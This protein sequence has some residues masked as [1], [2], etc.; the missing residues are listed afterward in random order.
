MSYEIMRRKF[1]LE[2]VE[3]VMGQP[4]ALRTPLHVEYGSGP[5]FAPSGPIGNEYITDEKAFNA[6]GSRS[7]SK[8][9]FH[10]PVLDL[11]GGAG[12]QLVGSGSKA[13]I[14]ADP[15]TS[16]QETMDMYTPHSILRDILG[17]NKIEVEIFEEPVSEYDSLTTNHHY[18]GSRVT[19]LA[20]RSKDRGM[21]DVADSTQQGHSHLYI[22]HLFSDTDHQALITELG[23]I[24]IISPIWQKLVED[25]GMGIVRT[26]WTQKEVAH[27][28]SND[29]VRLNEVG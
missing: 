12:V 2:T 19:S 13:I 6:V 24:G 16:F 3:A 4:V 15:R 25:E 21:F 28:G 22:Q 14:N 17:D 9:D 20:L 7:W 23:T 27:R 11:D 29:P 10:L 5:N 8:P 18:L 1:N 26:P